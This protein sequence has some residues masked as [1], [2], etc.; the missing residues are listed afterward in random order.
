M[1]NISVGRKRTIKGMTLLEV[2][3]VL[4]IMGVIAAGVVVLAQRA[5]DSQ[6]MTKL[7][8]SLNTIQTAMVQSFR[9]KLSYPET[10]A[11]TASQ[12]ESA[13]VSMGRASAGDFLNPVTGEKL[14]VT[15][16]GAGAAGNN[17]AFLIRVGG[18]SQDQCRAIVTGAA[19]LFQFIQVGA[20]GA[21]QAADIN[22]AAAAGGATGI[23]NIKTPSGTG[24]QFDVTNLTHISSLC[25][26]TASTGT[27]DVL[28]GSR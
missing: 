8:Q 24:T 4:G 25:G 16:A 17:K 5:I 26:A 3:I 6:N 12:L 14:V 19:D 15:S 13:L 23:G 9:S 1:S 18:L 28:F 20:A 22:V 2:I 27:F 11:E 7:V 10:T 21:G